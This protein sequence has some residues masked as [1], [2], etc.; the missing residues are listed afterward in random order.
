MT[1]M[2]AQGDADEAEAS[3]LQI[4]LRRFGTIEEVA[5]LAAFLV[6]DQAT[7]ITGET[8]AITGGWLIG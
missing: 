8:V 7:Y 6:S 2:L 4:P 1:P 5:S 3:R